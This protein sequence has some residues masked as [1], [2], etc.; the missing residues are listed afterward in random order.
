MSLEPVLVFPPI[1]TASKKGT[2]YT[3]STCV[4]GW[5]ISLQQ[6]IKEGDLCSCQ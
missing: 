1:L 2:E 4:R 3:V 5:F 6:S